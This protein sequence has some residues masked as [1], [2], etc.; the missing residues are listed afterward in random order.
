MYPMPKPRYNQ[1]VNLTIKTL[2]F[3]GEGI[4]HWHGYTLF[5]E[6]ALPG[7]VI[8]GRISQVERRFGKAKV[9]KLIQASEQRIP[10]PCAMF[11]KC[12]GCQ[13]MHMGYPYQLAFK[14]QRV[15]N[16]FQK[17]VA[18]QN[19]VIGECVPSP[20][21]LH[22]R[23]KIQLPIVPSPEGLEIGLYQRNS[24]HIV[25][26][27]TCAVHCELGE[28]V[29]QQVRK[30]LKN[31]QLTGYDF[32]T[33]N[34]ELRFLLIK[35][36]VNSEQCLVVFVVNE[37]NRQELKK[38]ADE[39]L[40]LCSAVKGVLININTS[41]DNTVLSDQY[42][43]LAGEVVIQE[44]LLDLKFNVS[45]ASFFQVNT[46]QAENLYQAAIKAGELKKEDR[47]LD[48]YCGVGTLS[49]FIAKEAQ[50]VIGIEFV[51]DAIEDAKKNA[52]L[53]SIANV[54]F[55]C[56]DAAELVPTLEGDLDVVYIN[57]PRKGCDEKV[58]EAIA[59]KAPRSVV[60]IS[61]DP[62]TL[63]RDL[64]FL[65]G[66]GY[67]VNSVQPFDMFP[68]TAHVETLVGLTLAL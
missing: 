11:D 31:S 60:Y 32:E 47:V 26:V 50:S 38:V 13:I 44:Q 45:A 14:R 41:P 56:G 33:G 19:L 2:G 4:G 25:D 9:S 7:E 66:Q 18:L 55:K 67:K 62:Q 48:A 68:Q 24:H 16:A 15:I 54:E 58:L 10:P 43:C 35:T 46:A 59:K 23:N 49:L 36:A 61:C 3:H 39:I 5:V 57:P 8:E 21:P 12:G 30:I 51:A 65:C 22:Y 6:D 37:V 27:E 64:A 63:A 20:N 52:E 28:K 34:G 17:H 42:E 40:K 53:N 29:Y 1:K